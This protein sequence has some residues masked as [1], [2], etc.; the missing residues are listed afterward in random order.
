MAESPLKRLLVHSSHYSVASLFSMISGLITFPLLTRIF[1]VAD[2]GVMNLVAATLTVGVAVGKFGV[3]HSI[4]RYHSE[5]NAEKSRFTL[6]Q[7]YSTTLFG[8]LTTAMLAMLVLGAGAQIVPS[9]MLPDSRLRVLL[10]IAALLLVVQVMDSAFVNFLR[11]DQQTKRLMLYQV[12]K[13]YLGLALILTAVLLIAPTLQAFYSA[14]LLSESLALLCLF[15]IA[16]RASSGRPRLSMVNFSPSLYRELLGFGIPMMIGYE[17]SGIVLSVGDRYVIEG[18]IGEVPLGLYGAAYNLCQ[19][20]QNVFIASVSQAAMP[21]Y[22]KIWDKHGPEETSA[23]ITRSLANYTLFGAPVIAG[24]AVVGPELLPSLASD[25]YSGA[26]GVLPWVIAGM[27]VDGA[28]S[29]LGAGLF[30]HRKTRSI[31]AIVVCCATLNVVLNLILV[32]RLGIIGA[33]ISTLLS[34]MATTGSMAIA[35][36]RLL[37]VP[38]PLGTML[39]SGFAALVMY[40]LVRSVWPGHHFFTVGLRALLGAAAYG[41]IIVVIDSDARSIVQKVLSRLRERAKRGR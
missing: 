11:A 15:L 7:L 17:L 28:N 18:V 20:V 29:I 12:G 5:I 36:R 39:R 19:Y 10:A 21:I 35:G 24:L 25:K 30:I 37:R 40:F 3:Q 8:M 38:L 41:I 16:F 23:F 14:S 22:M 13:K 27:V 4:I 2:Y 1:S 6:P 34:Y 9:S 32:P 31:M 26:V 33:G